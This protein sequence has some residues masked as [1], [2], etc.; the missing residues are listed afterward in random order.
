M[1]LLN[2]GLHVK[3]SERLEEREVVRA[4]FSAGVEV[5]CYQTR[6]SASE[7]TLV[8]W[9]NRALSADEAFLLAVALKQ[10]AI[11]QQIEDGSGELFGPMADEW[12]P[13][14]PDFFLTLTP[15]EEGA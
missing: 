14:N 8:A 3:G 12:G 11:A 2:I 7:P 15:L 13:F 10:E 9:I 4:L 1:V 6:Q 5:L